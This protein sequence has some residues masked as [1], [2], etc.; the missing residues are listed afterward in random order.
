[1]D[2]IFDN[3][4]KY[5]TKG[6]IQTI[7]ENNALIISDEGIGIGEED[8]PL[9]FER[10][11]RSDKSRNKKTDGLGLGLAIVKEIADLHGW[12]IKVESTLNRGTKFIIQF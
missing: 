6:T 12:D 1:L 4:F 7:W 3:A 2:N 5:S 10:F 9:I 8:L 11:Y